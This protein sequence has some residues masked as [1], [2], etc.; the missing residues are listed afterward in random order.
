[1]AV[2]DGGIIL[3]STDAGVTWTSPT[4]GTD[5]ILRGISCSGEILC[6][7]IADDNMILTSG[8]SRRN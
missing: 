4:S 1:V 2:G 3:V 5:N 7:V 6:V 8:L